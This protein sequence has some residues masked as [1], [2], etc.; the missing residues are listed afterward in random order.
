MT[1]AAFF[2]FGLGPNP[3]QPSEIINAAWF[4]AQ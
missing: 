2:A 3:L 4:N 1:K